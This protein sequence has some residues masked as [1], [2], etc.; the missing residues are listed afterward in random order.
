MDC[1]ILAMAI[2]PTGLLSAPTWASAYMNPRMNH[3][4]NRQSASTTAVVDVHHHDFYLRV[5]DLRPHL[6][7]QRS[8]PH[9]ARRHENHIHA[10]LKV[11][12]QPRG[13]PYP[14]CEIISIH[15]HSINERPAHNF[16]VLGKVK[17]KN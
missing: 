1:D 17:K 7:H 3:L 13:F 5:A 12:L 10:I 6:I 14:A 8:L 2:W 4:W 16:F 9:T 15:R 11:L